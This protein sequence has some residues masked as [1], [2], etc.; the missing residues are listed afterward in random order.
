MLK[1]DRGLDN[2]NAMNS[3]IRELRKALQYFV[4]TFGGPEKWTAAGYMQ[5]HRGE[6][7]KMAKELGIVPNK[8]LDHKFSAVIAQTDSDG[9]WSVS[10]E[11][12][13]GRNHE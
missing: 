11:A 13:D 8:E 10:E 2:Y 7:L 4:D 9:N 3:E 5:V 12:C 1:I 6:A